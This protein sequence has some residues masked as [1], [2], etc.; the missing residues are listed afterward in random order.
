MH[1]GAHCDLDAYP[2]CLQRSNAFRDIGL[3]AAALQQMHASVHVQHI[4]A[5][6]RCTGAVV[7]SASASYIGF[8]VKNLIEF[9]SAFMATL[10]SNIVKYIVENMYACRCTVQPCHLH[11][12]TESMSVA[13][14]DCTCALV[15]VRAWCTAIAPLRLYAPTE[16]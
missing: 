9:P 5:P 10:R 14:A 12:L 15:P 1:T 16:S 2:S 6:M 13:N 8:W 4:L 11:K 3:V 7:H